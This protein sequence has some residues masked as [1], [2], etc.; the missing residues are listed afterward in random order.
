MRLLYLRIWGV[1]DITKAISA[2]YL[3]LFWP[4]RT[5]SIKP[6]NRAISAES[7]ERYRKKPQIIR[8]A[9]GVIGVPLWSHLIRD[10]GIGNHRSAAQFVFGFGDAGHLG[11]N[12]LFSAK[13][14]TPDESEMV[15][16]HEAYFRLI[17]ADFAKWLNISLR[18]V[19]I[20]R[21]CGATGIR[22]VRATGEF[23]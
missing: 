3:R 9:T 6:I 13:S 4:R 14:I 17:L 11:Q 2:R 15:S 5:A 10:F 16:D 7:K 22:L 21:C 19:V 23:N 18:K 1:T 8:N 20:A 12:R